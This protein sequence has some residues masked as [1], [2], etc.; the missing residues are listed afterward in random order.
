MPNGGN[1]VAQENAEDAQVD[2]QIDA[3][4]GWGAWPD[5][6]APMQHLMPPVLVNYQTWLAKQ[7]LNV[8]DGITP[9]DNIADS[10]AQAW[11]DAITIPSSS[12]SEVG[13][14]DYAVIPS[15]ISDMI[16][17]EDRTR[18]E[19]LISVTVHKGGF[20]FSMEAQGDLISSMLF[21]SPNPAVQI[22]ALWPMLFV[23]I[24]PPLAHGAG[25]T[26]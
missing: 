16:A 4:A 9:V 23:L 20:Q 6:P 7:G 24:L 18:N 25:D 5:A 14:P 2:I 3:N 1:N 26:V 15:T 17:Q 8:N 12:S 13:G 21:A 11:N 19:M 22:N 10:A